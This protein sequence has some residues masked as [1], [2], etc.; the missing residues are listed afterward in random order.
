MAPVSFAHTNQP[1]QL[2]QQKLQQQ[3]EQTY[4]PQPSFPKSN[5]LSIKRLLHE[6][7]KGG[8]VIEGI[9]DVVTRFSEICCLASLCL[10]FYTYRI[11]TSNSVADERLIFGGTKIN[12]LPFFKE[13]ENYNGPLRSNSFRRLLQANE[14]DL[15]PTNALSNPVN[16][17]VTKM[18]TNIMNNIRKHALKRIT[19]LFK[20]FFKIYDV[21]NDDDGNEIGANQS[22]QKE[23]INDAIKYLFFNNS[24]S[25]DED[26]NDFLGGIIGWLPHRGEMYEILYSKQ[27]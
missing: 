18:Q 19:S 26:L 5:K 8:H 12:F 2:K 4:K 16:L 25:M 24:T 22:R 23:R 14:I 1:P 13:V 11:I 6:A 17:A 9:Q 3:S 10:H 20:L 15:V 27:W 7:A 21:Q